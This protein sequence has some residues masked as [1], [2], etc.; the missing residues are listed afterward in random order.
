VV[1]GT[2]VVGEGW[3][4]YRGGRGRVGSGTV[5]VGERRLEGRPVRGG[6]VRVGAGQHRGRRRDGVDVVVD[7]DGLCGIGCEGEQRLL[8]QQHRGHEEC[9]C[10]HQEE[11]GK[12]EAEGGAQVEP[13]PVRRG[14]GVGEADQVAQLGAAYVILSFMTHRHLLFFRS[15]G[16]ARG[17]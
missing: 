6:G 1:S 3:F 10:R 17:R 16:A 4:G 2:V 8:R 11:D 9:L 7:E 14:G 12:D 5:G 13:P 15:S